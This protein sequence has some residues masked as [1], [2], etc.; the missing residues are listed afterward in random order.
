M[1]ML[2]KDIK[3]YKNRDA[4]CSDALILEDRRYR[5]YSD[6]ISRFIR[7]LTSKYHMLYI[8]LTTGKCNLKCRYC[9]GSFPPNLVPWRVNYSIANLKSFISSDSKPVIAFY[10]GEPLLNVGFIREVMEE[11]PDAR[12]VI[13]TNGTLIGNLEPEYWLRFDTVLLS[14]DGREEVTDHYRGV[15]IYERAVEAARWLRSIGFNKD[16]VARMTVSEISDIFLDIG[17]LLS[18]NLFSYIHWQLNVI[19]SVPWKD[20]DVWCR[21]SYLPGISRL[22]HLW[23]RKARK[24]EVLGLVPFLTLLKMMIKGEMIG[25]PPC[26]AGVDSLAISTNGDIIAC[27]IAVDVEWAKLGN[28]SL[29][30]MS[31][32]INKVW[33]GE[34]CI[35]CSYLKYC[36]GRCLYANYERLWGEEGFR[37]TC[38]V[39][40]YTINKLAEIKEEVSSLLNRKVISMEQICYPPFNNTT[41]IIP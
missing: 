40:I 14:I 4:D 11:L 17:H 16:M 2:N 23:I 12:F 30:T 31:Q 5:S 38:E 24:G 19:W 39:T 34:P 29:G 37:K 10:G 8:V 25:R 41:E 26:G 9:G 1:I 32:M 28:I 20:F 3:I 35:S 27:P 6:N 7:V 15:G 33:I 36:G 22:V 13:Q 18:L 21:D